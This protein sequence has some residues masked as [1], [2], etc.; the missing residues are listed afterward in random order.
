[1][2]VIIVEDSPLTEHLLRTAIEAQGCTVASAARLSEVMGCLHTHAPSFF[3]IDRELPDGDGLKLVRALRRADFTGGIIVLTGRE[4][5]RARIEGLRAG[6]DDYV[7][8]PFDVAELLL[9][10]G[11]ICQ[12]RCARPTR[13]ALQLGPG[14][15]ADDAEAHEAEGPTERLSA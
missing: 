13:I 6:A 2:H 7:L 3:L 10:M 9:R 8:K 4:E 11:G 5:T 14:P 12:R 1:M 15:A